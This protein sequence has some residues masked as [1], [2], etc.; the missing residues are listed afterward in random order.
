MNDHR[1]ASSRRRFIQS[2][3]LGTAT[4]ASGLV[5]SHTAGQDGTIGKA[6]KLPL[7]RELASPQMSPTFERIYPHILDIPAFNHHFH[8]GK[9]E[10]TLAWYHP[11]KTIGMNEFA[12][13]GVVPGLMQL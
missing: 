6:V 7:S 5:G 3:I 13:R 11:Q 8:F 2:S 1:P 4:V 9:E 10:D 12:S